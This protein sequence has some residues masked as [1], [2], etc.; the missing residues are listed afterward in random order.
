MTEQQDLDFLKSRFKRMLD[1][2]GEGTVTAI[3]VQALT[4]AIEE[5][6]KIDPTI[7]RQRLQAEQSKKDSALS[8]IYSLRAK[9]QQLKKETQ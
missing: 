8:K 5:T 2:Y 1:V 4:E 9:N 6:P 3:V 7:V